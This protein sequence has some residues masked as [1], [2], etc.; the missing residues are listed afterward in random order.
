M[1]TNNIGGF[2]LANFK[3]RYLDEF[4][5]EVTNDYEKSFIGTFISVIM[6]Q[7]KSH[8]NLELKFSITK[9]QDEMAYSLV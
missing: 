9:F 6:I 2:N 8:P 7:L 5:K 3:M 4:L 1:N